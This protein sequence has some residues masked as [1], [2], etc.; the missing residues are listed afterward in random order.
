MATVSRYAR[1]FLDGSCGNSHTVLRSAIALLN[2][3]I[4]VTAE[5]DAAKPT[6]DQLTVQGADFGQKTQKMEKMFQLTMKF[7]NS[8]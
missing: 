6:L 8:P 7:S 4:T 1:W 5:D 2:R 3:S